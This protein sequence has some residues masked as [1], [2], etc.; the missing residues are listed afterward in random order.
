MEALAVRDRSREGRDALVE[1]GRAQMTEILRR[2]EA[3][4]QR[5]EQ[6]DA[7][8]LQ[9]GSVEESL[10]GAER[11][12]AASLADILLAQRSHRQLLLQRADLDTEVF[13]ATLEAR[14]IAGLCP[15]PS[16]ISED[17]K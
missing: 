2:R 6:I 13:A 1:A 9:S 16:E 11:N 14:R 8:V 7:A 5:R 12:G 17:G 10:I 3:A 4:I 15:L